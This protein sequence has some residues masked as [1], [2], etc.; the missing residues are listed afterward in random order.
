MPPIVLEGEK[1]L[2]GAL[3]ALDKNMQKKI[4]RKASRVSAKIFH[5]KAKEILRGLSS[6]DT[7]PEK[8]RDLRNLANK[9]KVRA[10]KRS[11]K[12]F[13][14]TVRTPTREELG[15][16]KDADYYWPAHYELG[17]LHTSGAHVEQTPY[18]RAAFDLKLAE[19]RRAFEREARR[20]V[21]EAWRRGR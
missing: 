3:L 10:L 8:R 2:Q 21:D 14:V 9:L 4:V 7:P 5:K 11:R 6:P 12:R 13:G 17:F 15:M 19:A 18:M 1:E 16:S 20:G